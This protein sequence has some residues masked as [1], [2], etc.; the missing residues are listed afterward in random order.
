MVW[1][2]AM[3]KVLPLLPHT[4][5]VR[6]SESPYSDASTNAGVYFPRQSSNDDETTTQT[7]TSRPA[8]SRPATTT[9]TTE[10]ATTTTTGPGRQQGP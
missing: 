7:T 1:K 2:P 8:T 9:T 10:P 5:F 4:Q 3:V 6:P